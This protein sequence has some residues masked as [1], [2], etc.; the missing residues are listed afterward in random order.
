MMLQSALV[1]SVGFLA[2]V[3]FSARML[4]QWVLS[5]R[6]RRVLSPSLF[7]VFSLAGAYLLC[8]YGWLRD[9]FSII[10]GQFISYYVYLWN[11]KEKGVWRR[12]H[13]LLQAVLL[14]TP[15][16]AV[17]WALQDAGRVV[18]ELFRNTDIPLW[19]VW[20]GSAGQVLFTLRFVYQLAYSRRHGESV[21]PK[22]FWLISLTG[23]L[24]IVVYGIIR[25][26]IVLILGQS[27]GMVAYGRNLWIGA[28]AKHTSES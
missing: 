17:A 20:F 15:W 10:L 13:R 11:L 23:S 19:L 1:L 21:L 2:Q 14:C 26:D 6:A 12:L 22:G 3:F 16:V 7:W 28:H 25:A 4:V 24:L 27:F 8:V 5:E 9:D 18:D